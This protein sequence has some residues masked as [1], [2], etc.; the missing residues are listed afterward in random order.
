MRGV[1]PGGGSLH[2]GGWVRDYRSGVSAGDIDLLIDASLENEAK[3]F[4]AP[5]I[6]PDKA[7]NELATGDVARHVVVRVADEVVVD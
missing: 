3:V 4:E 7:V 6:L 1:E 2:G 5:R